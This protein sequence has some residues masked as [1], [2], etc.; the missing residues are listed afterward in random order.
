MPFWNWATK[1]YPSTLLKASGE[2]VGLLPG[3]AGN[4][5]V[6]HRT[7]GGGCVTPT[8]LR[9]FH[10]AIKDGS[11]KSHP[12]LTKNL[13]TMAN[14]TSTLHLMGLLSDAGVHSHETHLYALLDLA[15]SNKINKIVVHP[16]L[17]GRDTP[18]K[19]A[20]MYLEKLD[21]YCQLHPTV[22]I[23]TMHGRFYAMDRDRNWKRTQK[24]YDALCGNTQ[25]HA[26]SWK[27]VLKKS[28]GEDL[29]DEFLEPVVLDK[30]KGIEK[31]DG[32]IFFNFRADRARQLQAA[33][34]NP[35]FEEFKR[36]L[37]GNELGFFI[38][39]NKY[40]ESF[41]TDDIAENLFEHT[42]PCTSLLDEIANQTKEEVFVIAE[43]EKYAHVTYFFR[44][45]T[46]NSPN[47]L[48][49]TTLVPSAKV[50]NY[51]NN[52]E[53]SAAEITKLVMHSLKKKPTYFYLVN[54]ANPDMVGHSGNLESA[55]KACEVIDE[56]L[57][58][59]HE[60][61]VE[62]MG[63]TM[64]VTA[65]H[66]NAE[67]MADKGTSGPSTSHSAN[68]VPFVAMITRQSTCASPQLGSEPPQLS[69]A[70]IAATIL[71]YLKL[72]VPEKM[73]QDVILPCLLDKPTDNEN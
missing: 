44:E 21:S 24:A 63:G 1:E 4:S 58:I 65:D 47:P 61:I 11:L 20:S 17:D 64:F 54:Y 25:N 50:K 22:S 19:S 37:T 62:K 46:Q 41:G 26:S 57:K 16:F 14:S 67:E 12:V 43:T 48:I 13:S 52:P 28:Y 42:P 56:Q 40:Q 71:E 29:T 39:S 60:Q 45:A 9:K 38:T 34:T 66:G 32:I 18:P 6:G 10:D 53:M 7:I 27:E 51:I 8:V 68:P 35:K 5:E 69:L 59:L 3:L 36:S 73:E 55:I 2:A 70:N 31:D 33:F 49:S 23:G 30:F 15:V 72:K